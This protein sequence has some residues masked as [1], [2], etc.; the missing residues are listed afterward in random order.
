MGLGIRVATPI[1]EMNGGKITSSTGLET[2]K[3]TWSKPFDWCDYSA[4]VEGRYAGVTLMPHPANFR[5]SWFYNRDYG[6]MVANPLG[7]QAMRQGDESRVDVK[8]GEKLRLRFG[9]L[10]HATP[11]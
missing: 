9:L 8:Q 4:V 2:A 1:I 3:H 6:L 5:P 7:R 11:P 10:V